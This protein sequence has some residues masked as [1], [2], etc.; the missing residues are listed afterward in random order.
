MPLIA[1]QAASDSDR[2][3]RT[4]HCSQFTALVGNGRLLA[5]PATLPGTS[6]WCSTLSGFRLQSCFPHL[7]GRPWYLPLP[8][9]ER[10]FCRTAAPAAQAWDYWRGHFKEADQHRAAASP[11]AGS[12]CL[13]CHSMPCSTAMLH[14][15]NT[16][17]FGVVQLRLAVWIT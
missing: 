3:D 4:Y 7:R 8:R 2:P 14:A 15:A 12:L 9:A 13:S 11:T 5:R 17:N 16:G 6:T 10:I 1:C